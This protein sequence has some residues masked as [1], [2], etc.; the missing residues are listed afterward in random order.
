M[1]KIVSELVDLCQAIGSC[2]D[3]VQGGGGNIS[4]K[5]GDGQMYIKSS[6]C[7]LR[8][9]C[10]DFGYVGLEYQ[11]VIAYYDGMA[12]ASYNLDL[13]DRAADY[14]AS[15]CAGSSAKPS[16]EA[17]MHAFLDRYVVHTHPVYLNAIL[18]AEGGHLMVQEL[19]KRIGSEATVEWVDF[20]T[21][22]LSLGLKIRALSQ[23]SYHK[24]LVSVFLLQ[25]HG[26][27]VSGDSSQQVI[28]YT[29]KIN[30]VARDM[31]CERGIED[32]FSFSPSAVDLVISPKEDLFQ[33]L[34]PDFAIYDSG[35]VASAHSFVLA[36]IS[37]Y[38]APHW[39][40][41]GDIETLRAMSMEKYRKMLL[42]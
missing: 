15:L 8:E 27:L 38:D 16:M 19:V 30:E 23:P 1:K 22:G 35:E 37:A 42:S 3:L 12:D 32:V 31:L 17:A 11:K 13:E 26:L 10:E 5:D 25:N 29:K 41:K 40:S 18:C 14:V 34:F 6:G 33:V 28:D 21:P 9:V 24:P 4:V 39:I 20:V 7:L 36:C 2:P